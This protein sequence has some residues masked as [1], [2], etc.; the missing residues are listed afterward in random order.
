[1]ERAEQL[2]RPVQKKEIPTY[3]TLGES[4]R[5]VLYG[6]GK[7]VEWHMPHKWNER[8]IRGINKVLPKLSP[9]MQQAIMKHHK[10]IETGA[11]VAGILISSAEL[12]AAYMLVGIGRLRIENGK[13]LRKFYALREQTI[14][15]D[16]WYKKLHETYMKN[17]PNDTEG[18]LVLAGT[19]M[20]IMSWMTAHKQLRVKGKTGIEAITFPNPGGRLKI[21]A[22]DNNQLAQSIHTMLVE[23]FTARDNWERYMLGKRKVDAVSQQVRAHAV[24][25]G[26]A[27]IKYPGLDRL[28]DM[29]G[30]HDIG[31]L[32]RF[33]KLMG[34][35]D[36]MQ[37]GPVR[38]I[39]HTGGNAL[40][41]EHGNPIVQLTK[42]DLDKDS[43]R[44]LH[45]GERM[46]EWRRSK[47]PGAMPA[48]G[49]KRRK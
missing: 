30:V 5:Q 16:S 44:A 36:M 23:A 12:Y 25:D 13:I 38:Y 11:K 28:A 8:L 9:E 45:E 22:R 26:Y 47:N 20:T 1:M 46:R 3:P 40:V 27:R 19:M 18:F 32:R 14:A 24:A 42:I 6:V 31:M 17:F 7:A 35:R 48:R 2:S 41:D 33:W 21:H 4:A 43:I 49:K 15:T 37:R 10:A 34:V 39:P 29:A